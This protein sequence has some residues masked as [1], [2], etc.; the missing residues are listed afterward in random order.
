MH[1]LGNEDHQ[2]KINDTKIKDAADKSHKI[3]HKN[4]DSS[5]SKKDIKKDDKK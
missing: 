3:L 1:F 5:A 4:D 2:D